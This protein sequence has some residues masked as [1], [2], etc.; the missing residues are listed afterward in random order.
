MIVELKFCHLLLRVGRRDKPASSGRG[1]GAAAQ[2]SSA[3][4][5]G[6]YRTPAALCHRARQ[7]KALMLQI[8]GDRDQSVH[9]IGV[10]N[11]D[12]ALHDPP[13]RLVLC[14]P[15]RD[16]GG[17]GRSGRESSLSASGM[18][19]RGYRPARRT[20]SVLRQAR[21]WAEQG[22]VACRSP[23]GCRT[24]TQ[25]RIGRSNPRAMRASPHPPHRRGARAG[26]SGL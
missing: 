21:S 25:G 11:A 23:F 26:V 4:L 17:A 3:A 15:H 20:Q 5:W 8:E 16:D 22:G 1:K 6:P 7:W 12:V 13:V 2:W 10:L 24:G 19:R 18:G 9:R 14:C